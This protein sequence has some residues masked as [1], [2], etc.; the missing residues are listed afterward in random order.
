MKTF[1]PQTTLENVRLATQA[2]QRLQSLATR[3]LEQTTRLVQDASTE[4]L[5]T[6]LTAARASTDLKTPADF[7]RVQ[8]E[9]ARTVYEQGQA[10]GQQFA[11]LA[12]KAQGD[13]TRWLEQAAT[14]FAAAFTPRGLMA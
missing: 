12:S 9:L 2:A 8:A 11:A 6:L 5:S 14:Q 7:V 1:D 4:T 13:Y 3:N 10:H